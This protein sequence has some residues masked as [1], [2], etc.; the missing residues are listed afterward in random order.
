MDKQAIQTLPTRDLRAIVASTSPTGK[1][2]LERVWALDELA[3]R[4]HKFRVT[5][6][7]Q[8]GL[9]SFGGT[10]KTPR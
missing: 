8:S 7:M 9:G 10:R 2:W 1:L 3:R 5:A 6:E 4:G